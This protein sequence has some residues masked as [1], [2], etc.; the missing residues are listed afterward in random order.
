MNRKEY[1]ARIIR[2]IHVGRGFQS[3]VYLIDWNGEEVAVKDF[4]QSPKWFRRFVAPLL[5]A[6]EVKALKRLNGTKGIPRLIGKIDRFAFA[7]QFIEGTPV[8]VFKQGELSPD[9]FPRVTEVVDAMHARGVAHGD[10]KRRTN[11]I[12]APDG[13]VWLV[14]FAASV[15]ARGPLSKRLMKAVAEVDDKSLPRIKKFA[16]PELLT[17]EDQ[18]KLDNPTKLERWAKKLLGR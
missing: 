2:P 1:Q 3:S 4:A 14:D 17:E 5:V 8:A 11:L 16:A 12:V 15:V 10:L 7:L 9:V 6:R 18:W 13:S